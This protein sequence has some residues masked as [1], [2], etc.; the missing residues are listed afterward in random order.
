MEADEL[1]PAEPEAGL[2]VELEQP[3]TRTA[4]ETARRAS[5]GP[6]RRALGWV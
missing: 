4:V 5:V 2:S 1:A 6:R 3:V